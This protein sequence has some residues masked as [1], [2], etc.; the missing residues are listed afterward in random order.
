[1]AT[2]LNIKDPEAYA[3][4]EELAQIAGESLT[5]VVKQALRE[6]TPTRTRSARGLGEASPGDRGDGKGCSNLR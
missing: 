1:M 2:V 6:K 4:A 3:L 5:S